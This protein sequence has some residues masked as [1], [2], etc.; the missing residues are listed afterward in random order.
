[1]DV[2]TR[3]GAPV[4]VTP[5]GFAALDALIGG[6]LR[7]GMVVGLL[8]APGAGKTSL[9]LAMAYMAARTQAGVAFAGRSLDDTEIFARLAAR[10]LRR[11]YPASEVTYGDIWSGT[12]F[13][14]DEVRRAISDAVGTVVQ[15]VGAH[16]HLARVGPREPLAEFTARSAVLWARHERVLVFVDDVEGLVVPERG[17]LEG[18]L[19]GISYE[20]R[21]LAETGCTVVYTALSRHEELLSPAS[22]LLVKATP[23]EPVGKHRI[24]L[25]L[26][27]LKNRLGPSATIIVQA[28]FGALEFTGGSEA[29][30]RTG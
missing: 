17:S 18:Q 9:A 8:G 21:E 26:R 29:P 7:G 15:K 24:P 20:L 5:T 1:V 30:S 10:A 27:V 2:T 16:L 19:V 13:R 11:S 4:K 23:L 25:E 6:G 22:T 14:G 3:L 28:L 12:A